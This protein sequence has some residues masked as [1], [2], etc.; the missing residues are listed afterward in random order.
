MNSIPV[1]RRDHYDA[2]NDGTVDASPLSDDSPQALGTANAGTGSEAAR[3]DHIHAMPNRARGAYDAIVY[4]QDGDVIAEDCDGAEID[5]GDAGTD[6]AAMIN[7]AISFISSGK[8][9]I[10]A[11]QYTLENGISLAS[12][13]VW[14]EGSGETHTTLSAM[15]SLNKNIISITGTGVVNCRISNMT[16][17][18]NRANNS[19][20]KGIYIYT[21]YVADD[22]YHIIDHVIVYRPTEYGIQIYGDTRECKLLHTT[23]K[24]GGST[25]FYIEGSDHKIIDCV[26]ANA[27]KHGWYMA[28]WNTQMMLCKAFCAGR[29][30]VAGEIQYGFYLRGAKLQCRGLQSENNMETGIAL[31]DSSDCILEGCI[32]DGNG[33]AQSY[34]DFAGLRINNSSR[35]VIIGGQFVNRASP[36]L[37]KYG[38]Q[39]VNTAQ[40]NVITNNAISGNLIESIDADDIAFRGN[41]IRGNYGYTTE[42][43]GSSTG[44]GSE[45]TIAHGL[46]ATPSKV[47]IVPTETGASVSPLWADATNIY[48]TVTTGKAFNWSAE[49]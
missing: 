36:Y 11:G 24:W 10:S 38:I 7:A 28:A 26:A 23:V 47:V 31:R 49:V 37:Q 6:D 42:A 43:S 20:G 1:M 40:N 18:G 15:N 5:S 17:N 21:P 48:C 27:E 4:I 22:S 9:F 44:T 41:I 25:D 29:T 30:H 46:V 39:I 3:S 14:L 13:N 16:L 33:T 35:C 2:D 45:Q 12:S 32:S 19:S 8:I 34:G